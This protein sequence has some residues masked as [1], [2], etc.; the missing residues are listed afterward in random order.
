MT[1]INNL[2]QRTR[3]YDLATEDRGRVGQASGRAQAA[4]GA[5]VEKSGDDSISLTRTGSQ[6][7]AT[8]REMASSPA[9]DT[10]KVERIKSMIAE[11]QYSIDPQR[12]ADRFMDL[13]A[14]LGRA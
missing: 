7:A 14:A 1:S 6:M 11:G 5:G 2:L 12:L 9:F 10:S 4:S 8:S 3:P 13:E